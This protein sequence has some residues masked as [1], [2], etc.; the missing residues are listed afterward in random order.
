MYLVDLSIYS[1]LASIFALFISFWQIWQVNSVK[2]AIRNLKNRKTL[3]ESLT[4]I[5]GLDEEVIPLTSAG[6]LILERVNELSPKIYFYQDDF[7]SKKIRNIKTLSSSKKR[8]SITK[9]EM[10]QLKSYINDYL[11]DM[12]E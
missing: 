6:K 7:A 5:L 12:E 1:G 8:N 2:K 11:K 10:I 9:E 4:E 3:K